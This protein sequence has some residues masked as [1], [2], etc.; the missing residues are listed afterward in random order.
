MSTRKIFTHYKMS[1]S[2]NL[3]QRRRNLKNQSMKHTPPK[4]VS[5]ETSNSERVGS[6]EN[7]GSEDSDDE[8]YKLS[9]EEPNISPNPDSSRS[10]HLVEDLV[11]AAKASSNPFEEDSDE[12]DEREY[13]ENESSEKD[14][15]DFENSNSEKDEE[16]NSS[17]DDDIEMK[18]PPNSKIPSEQL[19]SSWVQD[20]EKEERENLVTCPELL[21]TQSQ[22][23]TLP[24]PTLGASSHTPGTK[25]PNHHS[26]HTPSVRERA[27]MF[28]NSFLNPHPTMSSSKMELITTIRT[29]NQELVASKRTEL[30]D[31]LNKETNTLSTQISQYHQELQENINQ[32]TEYHTKIRNLGKTS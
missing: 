2:L 31:G 11:S 29:V 3:K 22:S 28:D 21:Q 20:V 13:S 24:T 9:C 30:L 25:T 27:A 4:N 1:K 16:E 6:P 7:D 23:S 14:D 19:S 32:T 15:E 10:K 12:E 26:L 5:K 8:N 17:E 18:D